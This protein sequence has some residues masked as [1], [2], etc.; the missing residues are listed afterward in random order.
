VHYFS[1]RF[2]KNL[3]KYMR[4]LY[5][6]TKDPLVT[7][8]NEKRSLASIKWREL[9]EGKLSQSLPLEVHGRTGLV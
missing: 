1:H 8:A 9:E 2:G 3:K 4:F 6:L 7:I 5:A